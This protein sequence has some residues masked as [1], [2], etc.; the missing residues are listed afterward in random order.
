MTPFT[1]VTGPAIALPLDNVD[2]DQLIPA[3]FLKRSRSEGYGD[4]LLYDQRFDENGTERERFPLSQIATPASLLV[5]GENFGCGSSREAAVY[6]LI[7]YGTRAIVAKSFADIFRNNAAHNGLLTIVLEEQD[8]TDLARYLTSAPGS[9]ATVDLESQSVIVEG[10][11][12]FKF[13]IDPAVKNRLLLGLDALSE[14]L[15][16]HQAITEFEEAYFREHPWS[17]PRR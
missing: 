14:T 11:N 13:D 7:D 6:A 1:V 5:A 15:S 4:Y 3:R 17:V 10:L 2:T 8:H 9:E 12:T 16:E